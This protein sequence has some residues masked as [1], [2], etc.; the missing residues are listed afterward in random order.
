[1]TVFPEGATAA[2]ALDFFMFVYLYD[3]EADNGH[4][5]YTDATQEQLH[6]K[7]AQFRKQL[8]GARFAQAME[9]AAQTFRT[10]VMTQTSHQSG[11]QIAGRPLQTRP[12]TARPIVADQQ[13]AAGVSLSV[14]ISDQSPAQMSGL[15]A[16][17]RALELLAAGKSN[18]QVLETLQSENLKLDRNKLKRLRAEA[19]GTT[20]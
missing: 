12:Q 20:T 16:E 7:L 3:A 10:S 8:E 2:Q 13:T 9:D 4:W 11:M 5:Q 6:D 18:R 15:P 19:K 14:S 1:L 17:L